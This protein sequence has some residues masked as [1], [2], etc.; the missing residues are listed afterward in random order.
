MNK[1]LKMLLITLSFSTPAMAGGNHSHNADGGH[2]VSHTPVAAEVAIKRAETKVN[3]L[4]T[5]G[6]IDS[7]WKNLAAS[8]AEQKKFS[9][10]LEWVI[11]FQNSKIQDVKK[12]NLYLFFSLDGH[13]IAANYSGK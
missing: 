2:S 12:Q 5:K 8:N 11:Q 4:V 9:Q 3:Q 1:L 7:S 6:V 10:G 13:Y